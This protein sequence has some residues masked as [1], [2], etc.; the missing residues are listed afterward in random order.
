MSLYSAA[1]TGK[2]PPPP[3][4]ENDFQNVPLGNNNNSSAN[5]DNLGNA[6]ANANANANASVIATAEPPVGEGETVA[7]EESNDVATAEP[8]AATAESV[9][10]TPGVSMSKSGKPLSA[11]QANIQRL[12]SETLADMRKKYS[13]RFSDTSVY[14][15]PPKA[16]AYH[17]SGLTTIRQ[18]DGEAAYEAALKDIMD[19]N[20]PAMG[21]NGM[22]Q[23]AMTQKSKKKPTNS[24]T[25]RNNSAARN[26]SALGNNSAAR[27]NS[28][29]RNNSAPRNNSAAARTVS[30]I[31]TSSIEEMGRSAKGL[32]DSIVNA[33]KTM[34][35]EKS[36]APLM[37]VSKTLKPKRVRSR[38]TKKAAPLFTVPEETSA[39]AVNA[40]ANATA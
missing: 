34:S 23:R 38:T 28:A 20:D 19:K 36:I 13:E 3:S 8:V 37:N 10:A 1:D 24:L 18:R 39:N 35:R 30:N 25:M 6:V 29:L 2:V 11:A 9:T 22:S 40:T 33:A 31:T 12:R 4:G 15:K 14:P 7:T 26:N 27:N 16:K 5:D 21:A 32:I 17:A